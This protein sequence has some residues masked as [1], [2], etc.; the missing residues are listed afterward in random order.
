MPC[1]DRL[2]DIVDVD[3]CTGKLYGVVWQ[4]VSGINAP[5]GVTR[6]GLVL[7]RWRKDD[8]RWLCY[9]FGKYRGSAVMNGLVSPEA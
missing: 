1:V 4:F 5:E 7:T 2:R 3:H 9:H 6:E 8:G